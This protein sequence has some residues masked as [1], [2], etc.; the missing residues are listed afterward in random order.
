MQGWSEYL[1]YL[2]AINADS[3]PVESVGCEKGFFA[4]EDRGDATVQLDSYVDLLFTDGALNED[5]ENHLRLVAALMPALDGCEQWWAT[6]SMDLQRFRD[7]P[8]CVRPWGLM[9]RVC[10]Y[11]RSE[12][13]ARR[14]WGESLSR[15]GTA[16]SQLPQNFP[17]SE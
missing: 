11:G 4:V 12:E 14:Y 6:S 13:E 2:E 16:V 1:R 3:S 8:G 10:N 7:L 9:V 17:R 5:P 15:L